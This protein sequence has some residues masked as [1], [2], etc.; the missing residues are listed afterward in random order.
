MSQMGA[1]LAYLLKM[2][3]TLNVSCLD[4]RILCFL[5][6]NL[7]LFG[8]YLML[9]NFRVPWL[10]SHSIFNSWHHRT[11]MWQIIMSVVWRSIIMLAATTCRKITWTLFTT[12]LSFWWI[13]MTLLRFVIASVAAACVVVVVGGALLFILLLFFL[14]LFHNSLQVLIIYFLLSK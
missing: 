7:F 2:G 3:N 10:N 11:L 12:L 5:H 6:L 8:I 13:S 4:V 14:Y 1:K 9:L